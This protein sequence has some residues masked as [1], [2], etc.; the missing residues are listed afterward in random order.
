MRFKLPLALVG[1]LTLSIHPAGAAILLLGG[2]GGTNT[3]PQPTE[4]AQTEENWNPTVNCEVEPGDTIEDLLLCLLDG[5][6]NPPPPCID[7]VDP[8]GENFGGEGQNYDVAEGDDS[9]DDCSDPQDRDDFIVTLVPGP[10]PWGLEILTLDLLEIERIAL[11]ENDPGIQTTELRL[12]RTDRFVRIGEIQE[13]PSGV[14]TIQVTLNSETIR[15]P[16][17]NYPTAVEL[18][19]ALIAHIRALGYI[20]EYLSPHIVVSQ[21]LA[22]VKPLTRVQFRSTD[23]QIISSDI[24]IFPVVRPE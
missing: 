24:G 19:A 21:G 23:P 4:G 16:T 2:S 13:P 18:T 12:N 14:G 3:E 7:D 5:I 17:A 8:E 22:T 15:I 6:A 11:W 20:V 1:A 9:Q 10:P